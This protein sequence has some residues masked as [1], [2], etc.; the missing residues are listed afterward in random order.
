M[1]WHIAGDRTT[2]RRRAGRSTTRAIEHERGAPMPGLA[3]G[4]RALARPAATPTLPGPGARRRA[5][6]ATRRRSSPR[7]SGIIPSRRSTRPI[8]VERRAGA[9]ARGL[10]RRGARAAHP[11]ARLARV[12]AD[13]RRSG[14]PATRHRRR[15]CPRAVRDAGQRVATPS[16][17]STFVRLRYDVHDGR[18]VERPRGRVLAALDRLEGE[19]GDGEYLVGDGSLRRRPTAAALFY[20][21][22]DGRPR[23]RSADYCADPSSA[24]PLRSRPPRL[25]RRSPEMLAPPPASPALERARMRPAATSPRCPARP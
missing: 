21:L 13:L 19:L 9:R 11:A 14:A 17:R 12:L 4:G 2:T 18:G 7:S 24:S 1:L 8:P 16:A 10:L 22:V 23:A 5:R 25:P 3:H 20:P 6:S 15:T